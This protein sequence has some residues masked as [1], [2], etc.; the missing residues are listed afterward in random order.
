MFT[1]RNILGYQRTFVPRLSR[2]CQS[3][4]G[5]V[6]CEYREHLGLNCP[7]LSGETIT[8]GNDYKSCPFLQQLAETEYLKNEVAK[9]Q[10]LSSQSD[11]R[12]GFLQNRDFLHAPDDARVGFDT[13]QYDDMFAKHVESI[14]V[15]GRYR[16]F[17]DLKRRR[18]RYPQ[19][20]LY[21]R[22]GNKKRDVTIWCSNDYLGMGQHPVV[23]D[24][25]KKAIDECG[26]GAGG[27]R[28]IAGTNHYHVLLENELASLHKQE[29]ALLFQS[30]YVANDTTLETLLK[31]IPGAV[32][33]SD[34]HNHASMIQGIR[35]SGAE[36]Q[37]YRHND[38]KHLEELLKA[39][40]QSR[41]KVVAFESVNSMEG[42]IAPIPEIVALSKK[43]GAL[44]FLD[45]VHAV[46]MYGEQGAGVAERDGALPYIGIIAGTLGKAY[47]VG[48][49]YIAGSAAMVDAIRSSAPGL[50]FTT[51][52]PPP[53]ASAAL[54][55]VKYLKASSQERDK[56]HEHA[57]ILQQLLVKNNL[58]LMNTESHIVPILVGDSLRCTELCS[59]LLS[60]YGMYVQPINY[61]TVPV[62]TERIRL[63]PSPLHSVDKLYEIVTALVSLWDELGLRRSS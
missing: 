5:T 43:Y 40:D 62:G 55:S 10:N 44:T 32:V 26:A 34:E 27:T 59:K 48:G 9:D 23:V 36:K 45:E 38:V 22:L 17:A 39:C 21:S 24:G 53:V 14:K 25:M 51:A 37:I 49:G 54:E 52:L 20:K 50:I 41:P 13:G 57:N 29:A 15:E 4:Q 58:P 35:H 28:N 12:Q 60:E 19:A 11:F 16:T 61:P 46:G 47:G 18:G 6:R 33:F 30:C 56:M 3:S 1:Q 7:F 2:R 63:S 8:A 31:I 42:T